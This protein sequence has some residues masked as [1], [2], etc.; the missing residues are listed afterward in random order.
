MTHELAYL[1]SLQGSG[2]RPGLGRMRMFLRAAGNPHRRFPSVLV[3]GTNGKGST[4]ATLASILTAAGY[5]TALYTSPHLV[6]IRERWIVDRQPVAAAPL[7]AAIR[8]LR[9]AHQQLGFAP[10]YFEALTLIAFLLFEDLGV[11]VA[12]LEVGMGGRLDATNVVRP[13]ASLITPIGLDHTEWLGTTI[14][15]VAREKAGIIHRGAIALTSADDPAALRVI[16]ARAAKVGARLHRLDREVTIERLRTGVDG[17]S[18]AYRSRGA[19][20]RLR[21]P[22]AGEHQA[23]NVALA[24]RAAELLA[25]RFPRIDARAIAAG[26]AATRWRGRLERFELAGAQVWVDGGHNPHALRRVAAFVE[27]HVPEPRAL[28]FGVLREKDFEEMAAILVPLFD[29]VIL[30]EP[31][32]DRAV[33]A[34]G[35]KAALAPMF[36]AVR[37]I[38]SPRAAIRAAMEAAP[39]V[40]VC[41]SLYLA[42]EAIAF[43]DG[44]RDSVDRDQ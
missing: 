10:T 14:A 30:T 9:A 25:R 19:T 27:R 39:A 31:D 21:S 40:L 26:V 20:L 13:L 41:G 28:V 32:S 12:V 1:D 2:I 16:A 43:L 36:P 7:R 4:A 3:A 6:S 29:A 17:I 42:G 23:D 8:R 11:D 44:V 38:R 35:A 34:R 33:P 22:L 18:F 5:R 15:R 37:A 24:A